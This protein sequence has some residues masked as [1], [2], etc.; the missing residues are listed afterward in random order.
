MSNQT[1]RLLFK[2]NFEYNANNN[3]LTKTLAKR[4]YPLKID[5]YNQTEFTV[6]A[7]RAIHFENALLSFLYNEALYLSN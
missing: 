7:N 3:C 5:I 2:M 4:N 6:F 1:E